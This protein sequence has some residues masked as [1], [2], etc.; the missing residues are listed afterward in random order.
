VEKTGVLEESCR[1]AVRAF[2]QLRMFLARLQLKMNRVGFFIRGSNMICNHYCISHSFSSF[3]V[4]V[5]WCLTPLST[6]FWLHCG[7]QF[8]R[9]RKPEYPEKTPDLSQVT[10]KLDHIMLYLVHLAIS[11]IWT[12]NFRS[13]STGSRKW[14]QLSD[15]FQRRLKTDNTFWNLVSFVYFWSTKNPILFNGPSSEFSYQVWFQLV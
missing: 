8:Y 4:M 9:W 3:R 11:G 5:Q 13:D 1:C 12:H 7:G 6:I 15:G 10:D 14:F 2:Y